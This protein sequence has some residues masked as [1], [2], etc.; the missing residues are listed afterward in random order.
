[1]VVISLV[2]QLSIYEISMEMVLQKSE[3]E[4]SLTTMDELIDEL[5]TS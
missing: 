1:M 2:D 4:R 5:S 3:Y